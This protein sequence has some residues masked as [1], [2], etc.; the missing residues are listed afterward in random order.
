MEA[1]VV[2]VLAGRADTPWRRRH[3][4]G[5]DDSRAPV[6]VPDI[7]DERE[8]HRREGATFIDPAWAIAPCSRCRC[9]A[10]SKSWAALTVWRRQDWGI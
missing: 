3:G 10:N 5:S 8:Y 6:Q 7:S 2:E 9:C 1:E 4:P